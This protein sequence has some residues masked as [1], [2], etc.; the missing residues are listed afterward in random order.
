MMSSAR[1]QWHCQWVGLAAPSHIYQRVE[2]TS[3]G[4]AHARPIIHYSMVQFESR[5]LNPVKILTC[6]PRKDSGH[7]IKN[8][9][10]INFE[11][12]TN[13]VSH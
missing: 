11:D 12:F 4:L 2:A 10:K 7:K 6:V 3:V 13:I 1:G 8:C 5:N 9:K